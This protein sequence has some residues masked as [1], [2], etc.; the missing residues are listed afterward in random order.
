MGN[1]LRQFLRRTMGVTPSENTVV[2]SFYHIRGLGAIEWHRG[3]FRTFG[4]LLN[5]GNFLK[6]GQQG[7]LLYRVFCMFY[8]FC[9][10]YYSDPT[11]RRG[12]MQ[13]MV[14]PK[15]LKNFDPLFRRRRKKLVHFLD[16]K[17]TFQG[18]CC[19][20][21][22]LFIQNPQNPRGIGVLHVLH[23]LL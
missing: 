6:N 3:G 16:R 9:I 7:R 15:A 4:A 8:M 18:S 22:R 19:R 17:W 11:P 1:K 10:F 5:R 13:N 21:N 2:G 23:F 20:E 14:A 12:G